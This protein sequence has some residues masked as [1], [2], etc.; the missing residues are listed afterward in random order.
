MQEFSS[1]NKNR[2]LITFP[3]FK[4]LMLIAIMLQFW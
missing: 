1:M 4:S 2:K 3:G